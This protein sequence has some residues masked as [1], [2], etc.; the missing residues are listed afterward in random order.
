MVSEKSVKT[1][2]LSNATF[3]NVL[4]YQHNVTPSIHTKYVKTTHLKHCHITATYYYFYNYPIISV[5]IYE[6]FS[7]SYPIL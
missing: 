3:F 5:I 7:R 4:Q 6:R 2:L 1:A